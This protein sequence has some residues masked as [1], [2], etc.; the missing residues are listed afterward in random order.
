M[1]TYTLRDDGGVAV[2][3]VKR[4]DTQVG[5]RRMLIYF[6]D[7]GDDDAGEFFVERFYFFN[8]RADHGQPV[9]QFVGRPVEGDIVFKPCIR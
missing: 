2:N 3:G 7:P 4:T 5:P 6:F 9:G 1:S 8:R